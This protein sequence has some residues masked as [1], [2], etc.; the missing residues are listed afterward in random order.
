MAG[1]GAIAGMNWGENSRVGGFCVV[2][3]MFNEQ[4]GAESCVRRISEVLAK[5]P[6]RSALVT[7]NDG[8][9]DATPAIL[10]RLSQNLSN[11]TV[12]HHKT[13]Q[14]YGAALRTGIEHA[15]KAL[16]DYALFMDSDLT[17]DPADIPRFVEKMREG[18]DVIKATRYS[19][20]GEVSG[21]SGKLDHR[22]QIGLFGDVSRFADARRGGLVVVHR[23]FSVGDGRTI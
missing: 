20:G 5:L 18:Y 11:V 8:S 19:E 7:V 2:V 10:N 23:D 6:Q 9:R 3:P 12:I 21:G 13:N 14:G 17:N 15:A 4:N 16:F 22:G 1:G